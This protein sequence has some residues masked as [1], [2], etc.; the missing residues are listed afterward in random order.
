MPG[1]PLDDALDALKRE[2][3]L[4]REKLSQWE[5]AVPGSQMLLAGTCD[6]CEVCEKSQG[7]PCRH[8]ECL[9]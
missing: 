5:Q 7:R 1:Q 9:R 4:Y 6:Q 3:R 8:P 2:K